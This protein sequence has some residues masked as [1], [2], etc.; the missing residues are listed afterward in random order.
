MWIYLTHWQVYPGLEA[1]G[2]PVAAVLASIAVGLVAHRTHGWVLA[3]FRR[4]TAST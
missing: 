1:A 4:H 2:H 3:R